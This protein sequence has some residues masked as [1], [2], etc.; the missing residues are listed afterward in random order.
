L[1]YHTEDSEVFRVVG[2]E[3]EP[4]SIKYGELKVKDGKCT[5]DPPSKAIQPQEIIDKCRYKNC[6][7]G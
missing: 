2:F 6:E 3:V 7:N 1:K 4:K 5:V